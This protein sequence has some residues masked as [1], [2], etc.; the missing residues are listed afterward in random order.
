[1]SI[2][3]LG[4]L[5]F[6][7][8]ASAGDF[9][10]PSNVLDD[11]TT[12]GVAGTFV[13]LATQ[14]ARSGQQWG[15][16]GTEFTGTLIIPGP[17]N[18]GT[19]DVLGPGGAMRKL[20]TDDATGVY[21]IVGYKMYPTVA[22]QN[23]A[24]PFGVYRTVDTTHEEQLINMSGIARAR[25]QWDWFDDDPEVVASIMDAAR[26]AAARILNRV[27]TI[28]DAELDIKS[29]KLENDYE[30]FEPIIDASGKPIFNGKQDF[31]VWFAETIPTR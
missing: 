29:I 17:D 28:G 21:S 11:D 12:D 13:N 31:F 20:F 24:L 4:S 25:I 19:G 30:E 16:G 27:I 3:S 7:H 15:A 26:L 6:L 14:H 9:P 23:A 8:V 5:G 18:A 1:M 2:A 22:P 10:D